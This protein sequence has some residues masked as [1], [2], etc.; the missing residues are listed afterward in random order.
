MTCRIAQLD[1]LSVIMGINRKGRK[2]VINTSLSCLID[3]QR[4]LA[5]KELCALQTS[6]I[7]GIR[8]IHTVGL[9]RYDRANAVEL[10]VEYER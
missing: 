10:D 9:Y 2:S 7:I 8:R 3:A 1:R 5:G 4:F 6:R